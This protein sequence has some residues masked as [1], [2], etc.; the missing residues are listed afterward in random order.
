MEII[1][2]Q[3]I[4]NKFLLP[5]DVIDIIKEYIFHTIKKIPKYDPRYDLLVTI[6]G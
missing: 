2:K 6:P 4:I 1:A 3:I 5:K